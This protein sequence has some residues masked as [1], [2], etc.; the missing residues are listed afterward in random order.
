MSTARVWEKVNY[1]ESMSC[2]SRTFIYFNQLATHEGLGWW[3]I[4]ERPTQ[5]TGKIEIKSI[6]GCPVCKSFLRSVESI[7]RS[8]GNVLHILTCDKCN[9]KWKELWVIMG[10]ANWILLRSVSFFI[11]YIRQ[12]FWIIYLLV[13]WVAGP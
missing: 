9:Y 8:D 11:K 4:L 1:L 7:Q 3:L 13:W 10:D 6:I 5:L 12:N 2:T